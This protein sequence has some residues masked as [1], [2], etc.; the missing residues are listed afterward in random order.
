MKM[1]NFSLKYLTIV[2][3]IVSLTISNIFA[4]RL[5]KLGIGGRPQVETLETLR[6]YCTQL[7]TR[8]QQREQLY[9]LLDE[10]YKDR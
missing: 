3:L 4:T 10:Q 9:N 8:Y 7:E 5:P 1:C 6:E 2:S